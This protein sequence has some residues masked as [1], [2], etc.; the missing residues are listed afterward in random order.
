[1]SLENKIHASLG[2]LQKR[3]CT[4]MFSAHIYPNIQTVVFLKELKT[5]V[6]TFHS[7]EYFFRPGTL[8][9]KHRRK[10][11]IVLTGF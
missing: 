7:R 10:K 8:D 5:V 4:K 1:M 11:N 2:K 6:Y 3:A 9:Y